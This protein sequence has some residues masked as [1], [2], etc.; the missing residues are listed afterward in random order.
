MVAL[1][2]LA[3]GIICTSP[4]VSVRIAVWVMIALVLPV[5]GIL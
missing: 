3:L 2:L 1:E 4:L 5:L